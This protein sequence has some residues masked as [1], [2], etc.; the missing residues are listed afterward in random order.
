MSSN[1]GKR[2]RDQIDDANLSDEEDEVLFGREPNGAPF[3]SGLRTFKYDNPSE[4]QI[5]LEDY[6]EFSTPAWAR[7]GVFFGNNINLV[8]L[9]L[10]WCWFSAED[11]RVLMDGLKRSNSLRKLCL[12]Q[13]GSIGG[14]EGMATVASYV[15]G[16]NQLERLVLTD[17]GLKE[18]GLSELVPALNRSSVQH[19]YLGNIV[20]FIRDGNSSLGQLNPPQLSLLLLDKSN[21][22]REGCLEVAKVLKNRKQTLKKLYLESCEIDDEGIMML[23]EAIDGNDVLHTLILD[24]N[25]DITSVG[26]DRIVD[27][28]FDATSIESLFLSNHTLVDVGWRD[29]YPL[30]VLGS[31]RGD[32]TITE[33]GRHKVFGRHFWGELEYAHYNLG[34]IIDLDVRLMPMVLEWIGR[35]CGYY[36]LFY[37]LRNWNLPS[38]FEYVR[39][40]LKN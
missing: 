2:L 27:E 14:A 33:K 30:S 31:N 36:K 21:L 26:W 35:E 28:V 4:C 40:N 11:L 1:S 19:L 6:D 9:D 34:L 8:S 7:L 13:N 29:Y 5:C 3:F 18:E 16:N 37:T 10:T 23:M 20:H 25:T 24:D 22:A 17:T 12:A 39:T 38:L 32:G 15:D